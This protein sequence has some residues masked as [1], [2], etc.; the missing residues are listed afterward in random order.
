[1]ERIF[2]KLDSICSYKEKSEAEKDK[3]PD[4]YLHHK[5]PTSLQQAALRLPL[6][7]LPRF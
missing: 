6:T 1:M 5:Y 2:G 7:H 3:I 4:T